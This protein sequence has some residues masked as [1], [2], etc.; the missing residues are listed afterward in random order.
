[1]LFDVPHVMFMVRGFT[2]LALLEVLFFLF[3][4]NERKRV[5]LLR[6]AAVI[7]VVIHYS[8]LY[9]DY[10]QTGKAEL[11]NTML[12]PIYPCNIAMWFLLIVAFMKNKESKVY[13]VV[14]EFTFYLGIV[15][16]LVGIMFNEIYASTPDLSDWGVL[17]GLLSHLT[18]LFGAIYLLV[19]GFIKI[20]VT[21]TISVLIGMIFMLVDGAVIIGLHRIFKLDSPNAMYLIN[22]PFPDLP[23][24]NTWTIG[25]MA[26]IIVFVI[27]ASYEQIALKKEDRW[28]NHLKGGKK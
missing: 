19:G 7:T 3:V 11:E 14:A 17:K 1:M 4:K 24:I 27:T 10:F 28:Y 23:W 6:F 9:V 15:G 25:I 18:M 26:V 13:K 2:L 16:G 20:R 5:I 12:L 22:L 21:N 8:S